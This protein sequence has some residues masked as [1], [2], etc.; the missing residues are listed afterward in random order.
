[1]SRRSAGRLGVMLPDEAALRALVPVGDAEAAEKGFKVAT[2]GAHVLP[3]LIPAYG[4]IEADDRHN[5][6]DNHEHIWK[7]HLVSPLVRT[8]SDYFSVF[9]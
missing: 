1:M 3:T 5:D 8:L 7:G 6:G 9:S 4:T 2:Y